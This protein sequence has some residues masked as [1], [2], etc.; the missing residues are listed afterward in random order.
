LNKKQIYKTFKFTTHS[1]FHKIYNMDKIINDQKHML[2]YLHKQAEDC[3]KTREMVIHMNEEF[4]KE[5]TQKD[6]DITKLKKELV[7]KEK[8]SMYMKKT[9][10]TNLLTDFWRK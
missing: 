7:T 8:N 2:K 6:D 3:V 9:P 1:G 10:S 4:E 5:I